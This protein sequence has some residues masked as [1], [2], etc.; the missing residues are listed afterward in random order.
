MAE[1]LRLIVQPNEPGVFF[2]LPEA[3][4]LG[5]GGGKRP[6]VTAIVNGHEHR[7][8]IAVYGGRYYLAFRKDARE[9]AALAPGEQVD[10]TLALDDEPREVTLPDDFA[11]VLAADPEARAH[12][13]ALSFTNRTEYVGWLE[14]AKRAATRQR[15]LDQVTSLLK[16]GRRTPLGRA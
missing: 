10:V 7:T 9:A 11:A 15:R 2:E 8:R 4:V 5:L 13:E 3:V 6:A 14:S 1:T 12:F 16:T